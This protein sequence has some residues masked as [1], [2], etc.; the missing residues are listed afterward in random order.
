MTDA[1]WLVAIGAGR[2][3]T[4]GIEAAQA[5]GVKVLALDGDPEAPGNRIADAATTVDI[6]NV[7]ASAAAVEAAGIKPAGFI[8]YANEAG[9]MTAAAL[10]ERFDCPGPD[11]VLARRLTAKH[12]QRRLWTDAGLPCPDWHLV[13]DRD[14]AARAAGLIGGRVIVKPV[15]A[16]GSRG[17]R[18]VDTPLDAAE[19][20]EHAI[21]VSRTRLA[22]VERFVVG[23]EYT[24]ETFGDGERHHVLAV[25]EKQKVPGTSDT[26][27]RELAT[28]GLPNK[29][30]ARIAALAVDALTALGYRHGPG[31]TE[32]LRD[33]GGGLWLVETAGRGA[34]FLVCDR[35][36][37]MASGFDLPSA[38]VAAA[39]G[40]PFPVSFADRQAVVLRFVA[41]RPGIVRRLSGFE[42]ANT[43]AGVY[44]E[45]FVTP[46]MIVGIADSD[47]ARLAAILAVASTR[48]EAIARA[49]HAER[50]LSINIDCEGK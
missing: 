37:P 9:M 8:A 43:L 27:A 17:V 45:A 4:R 40:R 41:S 28:P 35:L 21:G 42:E 34:G 39:L 20:F 33:G 10:R 49:D 50:L 29:E 25:T 24:V 32:I 48:D 19:A 12:E 26:V 3:Q 6:R 15:D 1:T 2:W 23:V 11:Q 31:H 30:T 13:R 7:E 46:G 22:L 16:A 5:M 47:G 44:V 36:V 38:C 18:V 14:E